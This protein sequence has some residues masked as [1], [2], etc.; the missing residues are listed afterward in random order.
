ML[1]FWSVIPP[2][3]TTSAHMAHVPARLRATWA[4]VVGPGGT[5]DQ[6]SNFGTLIYLFKLRFPQIYTNFRDIVDY[7][8]AESNKRC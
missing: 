3:P 1:E 2:G 4:E 6:N 8:N 7:P 5:T